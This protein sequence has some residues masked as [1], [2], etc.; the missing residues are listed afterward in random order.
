MI[1]SFSTHLYFDFVFIYFPVDLINPLVALLKRMKGHF[2]SFS[3]PEN[4][5]KVCGLLQRKTGLNPQC[6]FIDRTKA[7]IQHVLDKSF[8]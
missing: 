4:V 2:F 7:V 6:F 8:K 1:F 3:S 5:E